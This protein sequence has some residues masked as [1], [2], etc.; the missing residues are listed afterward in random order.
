M[1]LIDA[2]KLI[3]GLEYD[4]ELDERM[5]DD[6]DLVGIGR[7][8][9][10]V[11][12]CCKKAVIDVLRKEPTAGGEPTWIPVSEMLPKYNELSEYLVTD[13][14]RRV[15][16]CYLDP[17]IPELFVTVEEDAMVD[18]VAWTKAPEPYMEVKE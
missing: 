18:A 4:V 3:E 10:R 14:D 7:E 11:D 5:L 1:R 17:Y 15:R 8:Y 16:H 9:V 13:K 12:R 2:D 6:T